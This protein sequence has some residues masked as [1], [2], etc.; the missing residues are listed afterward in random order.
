MIKFLKSNGIYLLAGVLIFVYAFSRQGEGLSAAEFAKK[1][2]ETVN[3]QVVDVRTPEEFAEGYIDNAKNIDWNNDNF[4]K[5]INNLDKDKPTFVYCQSGNRSSS[6]ARKMREMGFTNVY[7]LSG[8][9]RSWRSADL[10]LLSGKDKESGM[11]ISAYQKLLDDKRPVLVDIYA[12]WCSPCRKMAPFLEEL[13]TSEASWLKIV[14]IDA[15]KNIA[16]ADELKIAGLPT[17]F[18]YVNGKQV[19]NYSGYINKDD[20]LEQVKKYK[21]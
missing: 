12:K 11:N 7:E 3:A 10:P 14:S 20:L 16:L 18:L 21:K 9:I 6:A 13:T 8:G 17:L 1:I 15:D 5:K 2:K 4:E 19:W